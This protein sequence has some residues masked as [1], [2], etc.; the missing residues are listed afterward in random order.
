VR[1]S[2]SNNTLLIKRHPK[3]NF[4][5][6]TS[7]PNRSLLIRLLLGGKYG[8]SFRN[9]SAKS[10]R[11]FVTFKATKRGV[12]VV[13]RPRRPNS[14]ERCSEAPQ[15]PQGGSR[16]APPP[17][18]DDSRPIPPN[19]NNNSAGPDS[20]Q[21]TQQ[22]LGARVRPIHTTTARAPKIAKNRLSLKCS[23]RHGRLLD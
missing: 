5:L 18:L 11:N 16:D 23:H 22:Q 10:K 1:E 14:N 2:L 20:A 17:R 3:S 21:P 7:L 8:I 6:I 12:V 13:R 15:D 9:K 4:V 19:P